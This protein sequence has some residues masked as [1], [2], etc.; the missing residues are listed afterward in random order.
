MVTVR[1]TPSGETRFSHDAEAFAANRHYIPRDSSD[2]NRCPWTSSQPR[3]HRIGC[4]ILHS[5]HS[6][7]PDRHRRDRYRWSLSLLQSHMAG[8]RGR[9]SPWKGLGVDPRNDLHGALHPWRSLRRV[10]RTVPSRLCVSLLDYHDHLS[11]EISCQSL[12]RQRNGPNL[13]A[14]DEHSTD[15]KIRSHPPITD[16]IRS[17]GTANPPVQPF[18]LG[19]S[20]STSG[21]DCNREMSFLRRPADPGKLVLH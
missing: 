14:R 15:T 16:S 7:N 6:W 11:H 18:P 13:H 21:G 20:T 9:L 8:D 3:Y 1:L 17:G 2:P 12:L 10:Y 5:S 4:H 19:T